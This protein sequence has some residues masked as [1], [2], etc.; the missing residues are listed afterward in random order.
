[1]GSHSHVYKSQN[2]SVSLPKDKICICIHNKGQTTII[3]TVTGVEAE[4]SRNSVKMVV[5]R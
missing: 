2:S 1:M 3:N 4:Q 5:S